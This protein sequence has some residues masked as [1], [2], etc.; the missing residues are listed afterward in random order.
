[1]LAA[2]QT[3]RLQH[4]K[5]T[6]FAHFDAIN[7]VCDAQI[8]KRAE[9]F[10]YSVTMTKVSHRCD[11]FLTQRANIRTFPLD[12]TFSRRE[13]SAQNPE[14]TGFAASV[15]SGELDVRAGIE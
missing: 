15:W 14:Q 11:I 3:H 9:L 4:R 12:L 7:G 1:M 13:E 8:F 2:R 10:F 6:F 5:S